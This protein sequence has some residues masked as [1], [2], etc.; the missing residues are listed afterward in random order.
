[1]HTKMKYGGSRF[2]LDRHGGGECSQYQVSRVC[3]AK[4][5]S[6]A[7]GQSFTAT[8][9]IW[10]PSRSPYTKEVSRQ[11]AAICTTKI[12]MH[13]KMKNGGSRFSLGPWPRDPA[14][15]SRSGFSSMLIKPLIFLTYGIISNCQSGCLAMRASNSRKILSERRN[16]L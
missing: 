8:S 6:L 10:Q 14:G 15:I 3:R 2:S 7:T 1:M 13:T 16:L 12:T 5:P 11:K 4:R 9:D